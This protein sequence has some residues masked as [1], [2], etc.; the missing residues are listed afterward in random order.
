MQLIDH[1]RSY[2]P[3]Y[4]KVFV[5]ETQ[6]VGKV[7]KPNNGCQ[8]DSISVGK[9]QFNVILKE[10]GSVNF[11]YTPSVVHIERSSL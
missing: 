3:I 10:V 6:L 1:Q 5:K 8:L 4:E 2:C 9:I 7:A 11:A